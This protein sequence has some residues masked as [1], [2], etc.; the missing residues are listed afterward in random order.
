MEPTSSW[1]LVGS[2]P[3]SHDGNSQAYILHLKKTIVHEHSHLLNDGTSTE[4]AFS[5]STRA[6]LCSKHCRAS[7]LFTLPRHF[8]LLLFFFFFLLCR[9]TVAAYGDSQA[10]GRIGA[11]AASLRQS[12]SNSGPEPHL[13]PTPQLTATP[14][15]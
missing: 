4:R 12:H 9:A 13:R 14:D 3:L 6:V 11:A 8:L 2:F 15:R 7:V 5:H 1:I 10:R